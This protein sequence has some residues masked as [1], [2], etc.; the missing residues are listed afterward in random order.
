MT[1]VNR[2][3]ALDFETAS[4]SRTSACALG[5]VA[6]S[7]NGIVTA[8]TFLIRPPRP[9][10]EFTH[11]H[12]LTWEDVREAPTF[13]ELWP[14]IS[15]YLEQADFLVAHNAPFDQGVLG[16]CCEHYGLRAPERP[17]FCTVQIARRQ[18][19]IYPT[20]LPDVCAQLGIALSHHDAGSD[21]RACAEIA[22]RAGREGWRPVLSPRAADS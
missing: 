13:A 11:I 19:G 22:L 21:A 16:R 15:T 1:P 2:F 5:L 20:R 9:H 18:W 12:G 10:F 4:R 6:V 3:L 7:D 8:E 14:R 17:F